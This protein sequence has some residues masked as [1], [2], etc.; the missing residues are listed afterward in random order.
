MFFPVSFHFRILSTKLQYKA[1]FII[2]FYI[3]DVFITF[4]SI[5]LSSENI[6][7]WQNNTAVSLNFEVP[8]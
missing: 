1:F 3:L 5:L 4:F 6:K 8:S 7:K 2:L